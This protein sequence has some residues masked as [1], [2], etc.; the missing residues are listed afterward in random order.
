MSSNI[1]ND[2]SSKGSLKFYK[3][4]DEELKL[5]IS[6]SI[7]S[8]HQLDNN[9]VD[10]INEFLNKL[11]INDYENEQSYKEKQQSLELLKQQIKQQDKAKKELSKKKKTNNDN[12]LKELKNEE[13]LKKKYL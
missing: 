9:L 4:E 5:K 1:F 6:I 8:N 12:L 10:S 7:S 3:L 11:L 13:K 2:Y